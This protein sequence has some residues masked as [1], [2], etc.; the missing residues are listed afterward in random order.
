MSTNTPYPLSSAAFWRA[1]WVTLRPYLFFISG[2]SGLVGLCI[3]GEISLPA[4]SMAMAAFFFAYGLGQALT[5][6]FQ[7]DTDSISSPY[8]PLTQGLISKKQVLAVSLTGLGACAIVL[9]MQNPWNLVVAG[10][11]VG[12]LATYT[13]LKRRW[14]GGPFWNSWIV[15]TLPLMGL[16]CGLSGFAVGDHL[17]VLIPVMVSVFFTYA[18]FVLL[19]YF[20]DISAD[21]QTGYDTFPVRFGWKPAVLVSAAFLAAG[22]AGSV[23]AVGP[24]LAAISPIKEVHPGMLAGA[25]MWLA[26][27]GS[28]A[29]A[30]VMMWQI[31]DE[32]KSHGAIGAVVIGYVLMHLGEACCLRP[33]LAVFAA[34]FFVLFLLVLHLRPE[35]TQI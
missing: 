29:L 3:P 12:G 18:I 35:K 5:D 6:V 9:V 13:P 11:G 8:R 17:R 7:V 25:G 31:S 28:L 20:K 27:I 24:V 23:L 10:L 26:G 16:L 1:Y 2:V 34:F 22:A 33:N 15:A 30:H 32:R 21:R 4:F 14:W 19:G